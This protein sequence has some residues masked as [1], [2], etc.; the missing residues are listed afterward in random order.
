VTKCRAR[1]ALLA[2]ALAVPARAQELTPLSYDW[3]VDGTVTGV[4][5]AGVATLLLLR[6]ELAPRRCH[7]CDP[8]PVD[9]SVARSVTWSN[10]RLANT[11]SDVLQYV[12]P[13][14]MLGFGL[15]Q[16]Y[17]LGNPTA[18]WSDVLLVAEATS[19][20]MLVNASVKY[21]VGRARPYVWKGEDAYDSPEEEN[22][23]FFSG[24][25]TFAFAVTV[26]ASTLYLM[27][28]MPGAGAALGTGLALAALT[29]YLRM[30]ADQHYLTDVLTG[31]AV[32]SLFG[33]AI[34]YVFHR[35]KS[36]G[37]SSGASGATVPLGGFALAF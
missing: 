10:P 25:S 21:A 27:Q 31:A 6:L 30:A 14:G 1:F 29:A 20:A 5:A 23:S 19:I 9:G 22:L 4:A 34:P 13:A 35:P 37:S 36:Q 18:G 11:L 24:H 33:W 28:G 16:G 2:L 32:G 7:W 3:A 12:V 26:S 8:G 17:R 15:V